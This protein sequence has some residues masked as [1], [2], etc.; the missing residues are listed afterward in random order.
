[1]K[2]CVKCGETKD[3]IEFKLNGS[4]KTLRKKCWECEKVEIDLA[5]AKYKMENPEKY[6]NTRKNSKLK[7]R[8]GITLEEF[9]EIF[10]QQNGCCKICGTHQADLRETLSVDHCHITLNVRG[11]LCGDCNRGIGL[12]KDSIDNLT[13]AINYL[14]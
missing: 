4:L 1:M 2:T 14:R 10:L 12:F 6:A 8:Y 11:L 13:K 3:L 9:N 7:A 5:R